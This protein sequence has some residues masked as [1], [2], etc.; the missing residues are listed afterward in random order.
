MVEAGYRGGYGNYIR[1]QHDATFET[2][3]GH[4]DHF[5][6]SILPDARLEAGTIIGYVGA[7]PAMSTSAHLHYEILAHGSAI[8]PGRLIARQPA[9][10]AR[11]VIP[12]D[13]RKGRCIPG[14]PVPMLML[15][16]VARWRLHISPRDLMRSHSGCRRLSATAPFAACQSTRRIWFAMTRQHK[17][18]RTAAWHPARSP[19]APYLQALTVND[20]RGATI[21]SGQ[22]RRA[23][24]GGKMT[25]IRTS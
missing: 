14:L 6:D 12:R 24:P 17:K 2:A 11:Q 25:R 5:A 16:C 9:A 10:T 7:R 8:D 22:L 19:D 13:K 21:R 1:I 4:L 23:P 18:R 20:S 3:Y 15:R